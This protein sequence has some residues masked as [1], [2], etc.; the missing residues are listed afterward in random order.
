MYSSRS[1]FLV[2]SAAI[3][4]CGVDAWTATS[5]ASS[6]G[7]RSLSTSSSASQ[8]V[9]VQNGSSMEMKKGKANV[10][11]QMRSQYNRQRE[12]NAM[13]QQMQAASRVGE[14][15]FPV[16]N[17]FV[18]TTT[19][20]I[21]YPCGSFKGDERSAAL[22]K[23][24]AEDGFLAGISKKQLDGGIAGS[25]YSDLPKLKETIMRAYPQLR[26]SRDNLEFGYRLNFDGLPEDKA[27]EIV[28]VEP[29]E[30]SGPLD[31]LRNI[32]S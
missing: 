10:P 11:P 9:I 16:F 31:G 17:L 18:R 26:K 8:V 30:Q 12:M 2:F 28:P 22:S 14:D 19:Q 15:G 29:K 21:W 3:A 32:F 25:L 1:L 13:Q 24:Y 6:F 7:G 27:K 23:S 20:K 4:L 5:S